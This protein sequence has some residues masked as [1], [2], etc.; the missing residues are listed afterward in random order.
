MI[1]AFRVR[2][3]PH[4]RTLAFAALVF[5]VGAAY[6]QSPTGT[7]TGLVTDSSSAVVA[8]APLFLRSRETGQTRTITTSSDGHY[9]A[10]MLLPGTYLLAVEAS[11]FKRA[12]RTATVEAGTTTTVDFTLEVGDLAEIVTVSGVEPLVRAD[13]HQVA[14]VITRGQIEA[15]PL[16]GRNFIELAKL[17]PGVTSPNRL[18][19]GRVFVAPLGAG[20]QTIPR[21][22]ST[23][24]AVDGASITTPGTAG[25]LLQ[26]SQDVVQEFQIS[27][28]N[29]DLATSLTTNGA[30]NIVTRSGGN[31]YRG[32]GFVFYRDHHMA[33]YPALRRDPVDPNP[34]FRRNQT[35]ATIGGPLR[36]DRAF[37][38]VSYER[39][40]QRGVVTVQ[41][42]TPEFAVLGGIFPSPYRGNLFSARVDSGFLSSHHVFARY[43]HDGN[44]GAVGAINV[45]P[46]GWLQRRNQADQGVVALVTVWNRVVHDARISLFLTDVTSTPSTEHDCRGCFGLG[47]PRVVIPG[48]VTFGQDSRAAALGRR[49]QATDSLVWE[50]GAHRLRVGFDWEHATNR[51]TSVS[52]E[53]AVLTLWSP[54][55]VR[56]LDSGI[57]LPATFTTVHDILTLP[58]RS[59][60]TGVGPGNV[61]WQDFRDDRVVDLYRVFASDTWRGGSRLTFNYGVGWS[62]EPNALSH[63]L[64]KPAL[65]APILGNAGLAPP[66]VQWGH[67]SPALGFV[68][69]AT[70]DAKTVVRGGAGRYFDPL[71]STNLLNLANERRLLSPIGTSRIARSGSNIIVAGRAL[72]FP[73]PTTFTG[74]DLISMLPGIR[75]ALLSTL[76]PDNRDFAIRNLDAL[77][78]GQSLYDPS[79]E[80]PLAVHLSLGVQRE[81]ARG[82]AI[83]A[84]LVWRKFIHTFINGIDYNRWNS[85][86][87]PVI[88][89]C[90]PAQRNDVLAV[91][92]NGRLYFDTTIGRARYKGLLVRLEKRLAR[93]AQF[94]ATYALA[95]YVGAN[96]T[97]TGTTENPGGRV[98]GFNNDN[99]FENYGPLPTDYRHVLNV[100]GSLQLPWS[101]RL[102]FT[103]SAYSRPPFS[104]YVA[105]VDFNGDGTE[106]DLLPG[107]RINEFGRG[108]DEGDLER[109]VAAYNERYGARLTLP[110]SYAFDDTFFTQDLRVTKDLGRPSMRVSLFAEVFNLLNVANLTGYSGNVAN[111]ATFGQPSARA[112]QVFGSGGPR[113][114]QLGARV[115]F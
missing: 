106:D 53:P 95:S 26:V 72:D 12:E 27:T 30:V 78:E 57:P 38:F 11:G 111:P 64:T 48:E 58:L 42:G 85:A 84:D 41:P 67:V 66:P 77:K 75:A 108:L 110:T 22:G 83:S 19:D 69:N 86:S 20:F 107:T 8:H 93:R 82:L 60:T 35:G 46:S 47:M 3:M 55:R 96:G 37:F 34:A 16:N 40:D 59:F 88:P 10:T 62:H 13:H 5:P 61:R 105:G 109:L 112:T 100:S 81:L 1:R 94:L 92:S 44:R 28:V 102:A 68:W 79:Y 103:A 14:G 49:F 51:I 97:G 33:A 104:V 23:R 43:T 32:S 115:A 6:A 73:R 99:F 15:L 21:V 36:R 70:H 45:L 114:F 54:S 65:L 87:G 98:F 113:A 50:R 52:Q 24:V 76:D 91:C 39:H 89:A 31:A 71:G 56:Q 90:T 63:D 29:F 7:I 9:H 4:V 25:V 101:L 18:A 2:D 17:E 74:A 80:T